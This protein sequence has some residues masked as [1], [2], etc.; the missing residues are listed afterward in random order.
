[1]PWY[2]ART[3]PR[4]E[5]QAAATLTQ[6]GIQVYLPTLRKHKPRAGRR[7]WE[8]LFPGYLFAGLDVPSDRW[9]AARSAP[10]VAYFLGEQG[11]PTALPEA[12][13]PELMARVELANHRGGS[14]RFKP[15]ERV[16]ITDGPFQYLEAIFERT[17]SASGRSRV[18][19]QILHRLVP[20]ELLEEHLS[21]AG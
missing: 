1:M 11:R 20:A 10:D 13:I 5:L 7:D 4:K 2:V 14:P 18:L 21:N 9:L 15:G 17:L 3:K 6:R 16:I 8:P 12:F 19:V